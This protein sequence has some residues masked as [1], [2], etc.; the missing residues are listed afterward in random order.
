MEG[1][2][3]STT[4]K[5][6]VSIV[7]NISKYI[8]ESPE[9]TKGAYSEDINHLMS[10]LYISLQNGDHTTIVHELLHR[11]IRN[12]WETQPVQD[13]LKVADKRKFKGDSIQI[14]EALVDKIMHLLDT[15]G[16][17]NR[18]FWTKM[19]DMLNGW[20]SAYSNKKEILDDLTMYFSINKDLSDLTAETIFYQKIYAPVF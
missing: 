9:G 8:K 16:K 5:L 12:Y 20:F 7:N 6:K 14:E 11:Y 4:G 15:D 10:T 2:E 19:N 13:A 17:E 18:K 3:N 1:D